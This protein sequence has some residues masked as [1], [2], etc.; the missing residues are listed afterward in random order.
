MQCLQLAVL[1][2]ALNNW[3]RIDTVANKEQKQRAYGLLATIA[4]IAF[5]QAGQHKAN[6]TIATI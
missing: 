1:P 4:D 2:Y 3:Q 5:P 6:I